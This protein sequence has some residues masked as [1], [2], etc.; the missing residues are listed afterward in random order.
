MKNKVLQIAK[1][2]DFPF[3]EDEAWKPEGATIDWG[4]VYDKEL[5]KFYDLVVAECIA[6]CEEQSM[7][8]EKMV[9]LDMTTA[10]GKILYDG[11]WGGAKN[12]AAAIKAN[13]AGEDNEG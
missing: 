1:L 9:E 10:T 4:G 3:W 5:Q 7:R 13:M 12:C 2:A 6:L 8:A 11:M